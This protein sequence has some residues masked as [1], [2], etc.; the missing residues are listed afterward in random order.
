MK[1]KKSDE[2]RYLITEAVGKDLVEVTLDTNMKVEKK[3]IGGGSDGKDAC[4][5]Q[6]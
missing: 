2:G 3:T 1:H 5:K 4:W 6:P